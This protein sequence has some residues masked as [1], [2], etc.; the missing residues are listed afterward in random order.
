MCYVCKE[1]DFVQLRT[2]DFDI[3]SIGC[4]NG[5]ALQFPRPWKEK[6]LP[7]VLA[8]LPTASSVQDGLCKASLG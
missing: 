2:I 3:T 5:K 1:L 7:S 4:E 6:R 8:S